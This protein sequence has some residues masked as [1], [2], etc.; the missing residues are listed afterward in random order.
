M[1]R[2]GACAGLL[3]DLAAPGIVGCCWAWAHNAIQ[4]PNNME[5]RTSFVFMRISLLV[6]DEPLAA[7]EPPFPLHS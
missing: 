4:L 2:G 1:A 3:S 7:I 5:Q 6:E